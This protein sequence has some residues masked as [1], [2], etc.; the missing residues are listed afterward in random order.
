MPEHD[1]GR[2]GPTNPLTYTA[3]T[4][5]HMCPNE[6]EIAGHCIDCHMAL[7]QER[8]DTAA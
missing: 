5:C 3:D 2:P 7:E 8:E 1:H 4:T 6:A